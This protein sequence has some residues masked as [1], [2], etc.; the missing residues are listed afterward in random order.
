MRQIQNDEM[1]EFWP[2]RM[3]KWW[4]DEILYLSEWWNDEMMKFWT[5]QNDEM[6]KW[7][8]FN[9]FQK[10]SM[11]KWWN[12]MMKWWNF[13]MLSV[14]WSH[15]EMMKFRP[16][17]MMKCGIPASRCGKHLSSNPGRDFRIVLLS[18][19]GISYQLKGFI[20]VAESVQSARR[21]RSRSGLKLCD[22]SQPQ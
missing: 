20:A 14:S 12:F 17:R 11:M 1:M 21:K 18:A 4:N 10:A 16:F 15:D 19:F 22:F 2:F 8:N 13:R 7:W 9:T 3:M 6:M 5:F